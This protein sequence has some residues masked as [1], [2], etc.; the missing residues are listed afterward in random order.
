M[1]FPLSATTITSGFGP[2]ALDLLAPRRRAVRAGC[3][4]D[5]GGDELDH[6]DARAVHTKH[7]RPDRGCVSYVSV[8][9]TWIARKRATPRMHVDVAELVR[10]VAAFV[11]RA[12]QRFGRQCQRPSRHLRGA[13]IT[14]PPHGV[15]VSG[16][17]V[18]TR[19]ASTSEVL[20]RRQGRCTDVSVE[21]GRLD[22]PAEVSERLG[23]RRD[24]RARRPRPRARHDPTTRPAHCG[25]RAGAHRSPY[26][27]RACGLAVRDDRRAWGSCVPSPFR[28][29]LGARTSRS[30]WA[31]AWR[32][33]PWLPSAD[34]P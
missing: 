1:R 33:L 31:L 16:A 12:A 24:T 11:R 26:I 4:E 8:I 7:I 5:G 25:A 10:G 19:V 6:G 20:R 2:V 9:A 23:R 34:A 3:H 14:K 30:P 13:R 18:E 29:D 15:R 28:V 21:D 22:S 32:A 17:F 27:T